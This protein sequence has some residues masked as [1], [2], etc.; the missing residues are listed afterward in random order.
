IVLFDLD[1][2]KSINDRYGHPVGDTVIQT[3]A[4]A[5]SHRL[6]AGDFIAR[7]GGEEFA[8]ILPDTSGEHAA[9]VALHINQAFENAIGDM[10]Q[11]GLAC[12]TSAGIAR[13]TSGTN[14]L[15]RMMTV[16]DGALYEAKDRGRGQVRLAEPV[17]ASEI[18]ASAA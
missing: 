12:T 5:A 13:F 15:E 3:F 17:V 8:A 16:A 10:A 7:L 6:R 14:T 2:F 1:H 9:L 18:T 4:R 11:K